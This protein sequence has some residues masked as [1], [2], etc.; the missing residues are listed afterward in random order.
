MSDEAA[1]WWLPEALDRDRW[2][3]VVESALDRLLSARDR[4]RLPHAVLMVGPPGLGRELTAIEAAVLLTCAGA[5]APWA[6]GGCADRVRQ[7]LHPDVRALL[8]TGAGRIITIAQVREVVRSAAGRPY[9]GRRRVWILDG[10]EAAHFGAEAANAFL[11]TLEEPPEHAVFIL[12]AANPSAVLPTILSRCQQLCLPGAVAVS[13]RL[14]EP[15]E[16]PELSAVDLLSGSI[17]GAVDAIRSAL[18]SA[19]GSESRQL[20]RLP[21]LLPEDVPLFASVAAVALEMAAE[22]ENEPVGEE[23]VRLAADLLRVERRSRALNLKDR[24]QMVSCLLRW[25]R[26]L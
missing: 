20:V 22:S 23:L 18:S 24:R 10:V 6:R 19:V 8:P 17:G 3:S 5:D 2:G 13:R 1:T 14:S 16:L 11:K 12:L 4:D 15:C 21:Y 9:E 25:Y 7:G 26:E